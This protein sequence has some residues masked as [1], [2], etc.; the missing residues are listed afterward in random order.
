MTDKALLRI[1][2]SFVVLHIYI[3]IYIY[4]SNINE[5]KTH[6]KD[7]L[8]FDQLVGLPIYIFI[9]RNRRISFRKAHL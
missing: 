8:Y 6:C 2:V 3:Y 9:T 5:D 7:H 1:V 4:I